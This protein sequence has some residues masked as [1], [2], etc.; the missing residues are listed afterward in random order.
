[1]TAVLRISERPAA[2]AFGFVVLLVVLGGLYNPQFLS[3]V[4][5]LQQLQVASFLGII[6]SGLMVVILLG[7]IDLSIPWVVTI[8]GMT[9]TAAAGWWGAD[10]A[11]LGLF[12]AI[13][14]GGLVGLVN[15][16]GVAFLRIPSM[17]FTLG[18]N[19]VVQGIVVMY[20]G[21]HAPTD[22]AT[23]ILQ[24]L[25]VQNTFRVP[26]ALI[27][28][29][30]IGLAVVLVLRGSAFGRYVYSIGNS[31]R[32]TYL[33][34]VNTRLVLIAAF[35]ASG[36]CSALAGA[37]LAGYAG[38]A[39]QAMGDPYLLPSIAAVVLG[40]TSILGG[41]GTYLGT[42]AGVLLI[43]LLDSILSVAQIPEATRQVIYGG[44]ILAMMMVYGRARKTEG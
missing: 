27:V 29:M 44:I 30:L 17:V 14:G 36:A 4:Y 11:W 39:Y 2:I 23:P 22:R 43:T 13:L 8:G 12:V 40:G 34:G 1:M 28:W 19:A 21:G 32:V 18:M 26:H 37:M 9:A 15:G 41:S 5:L 25:A 42:V 10:L 33:S 3:A 20:T 31:E 6:A 35:I 38:K 16:L 7:Q 24:W